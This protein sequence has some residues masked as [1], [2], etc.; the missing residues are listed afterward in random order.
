MTEFGNGDNKF[1]DVFQRADR[2]MYENKKA[3][4]VT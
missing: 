1:S 4:K 3:T 2:L